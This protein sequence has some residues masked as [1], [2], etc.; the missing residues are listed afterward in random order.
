ML[1]SIFAASYEVVTV[2]GGEV[3][4]VTLYEP[5]VLYLFGAVIVSLRKLDFFQK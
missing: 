2:G 4:E 5:G 3:G 1:L